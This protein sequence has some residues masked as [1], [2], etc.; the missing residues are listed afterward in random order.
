M[1]FINSLQGQKAAEAGMGRLG[2]GGLRSGNGQ[3]K[4]SHRGKGAYC[5]RVAAIFPTRYGNT[6]KALKRTADTVTLIQ[7]CYACRSTI[8]P[9]DLYYLSLSI[10]NHCLCRA[11]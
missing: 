7:R 10:V 9:S 5:G 8:L 11:Q 3:P 2:L 4:K 1:A 6:V